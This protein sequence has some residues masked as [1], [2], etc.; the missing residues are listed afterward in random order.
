V[1]NI[2]DKAAYSGLQYTTDGQ[3]VFS[4]RPRTIGLSFTGSF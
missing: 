1:Q 3:R 2:T 4:P